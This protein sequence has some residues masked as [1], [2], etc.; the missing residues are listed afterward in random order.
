[1]KSAIVAAIV[2]VGTSLGATTKPATQATTRPFTDDMQIVQSIPMKLWPSDMS[3][4]TQLKV[5]AVDKELAKSTKGK[6]ATLKLTVERVMTGTELRGHICVVAKT[7]KLGELPVWHWCY[8]TEDHE[9]ELASLQPGDE[10]TIT[11][12]VDP[13]SM[14][15]RND[16][17][18]A[19]EIDLAQCTIR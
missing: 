11:G 5:D 6:T 13:A 9:S 19:L 7:I 10:E 1:M 18:V 14:Q 3:T 17:V 12:T 16:K 8:F 4:W 2:L 15:V